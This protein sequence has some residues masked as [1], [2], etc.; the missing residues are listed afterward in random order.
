MFLKAPYPYFLFVKYKIWHTLLIFTCLWPHSASTQ[1]DK[2]QASNAKTSLYLYQRS[3][4]THLINHQDLAPH[5]H[6]EVTNYTSTSDEDNTI[7]ALL[8]N[9]Y[10]PQANDP[11]YIVQDLMYLAQYLNQYDDALTI[12]QSL[13]DKK[14]RLRYQ[15]NTFR[16]DVIGSNLQI[17]SV[18]IY[19]DS[20]SAAKFKFHRACQEKKH[21]CIASPADA[22]LHEFLHAQTA[23]LQPEDFIA[24]G[25]FNNVIYPCLL[26]TSPSPRDA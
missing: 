26:Y 14:W 3:T 19:F 16:T 18:N 12:I 6:S 22:L 5:E 20:R 7:S 24:Q 2:I 21:H 8:L 9:H 11:A 17:D 23:L 4:G 25:G 1:G 10:Q 13:E 15:K